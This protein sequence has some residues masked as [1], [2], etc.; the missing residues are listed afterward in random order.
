LQ[1]KGIVAEATVLQGVPI[2][3]AGRFEVGVRDEWLWEGMT[4]APD[5]LLV[6]FDV[7][8]FEGL[9]VEVE[10]SAGERVYE[11]GTLLLSSR[12]PELVLRG[13][14]PAGGRHGES[15]VLCSP[16]APLVRHY[17]DCLL[18]GER[19]GA[20]V[21]EVYLQKLLDEAGEARYEFGRLRYSWGG[22]ED[23]A[24]S[25]LVLLVEG[26]ALPFE[27]AADGTYSPVEPVARPV[28]LEL[29]ALPEGA[30]R[31]ELAWSWRGLVVPL[32]VDGT[33]VLTTLEQGDVLTLELA[34]PAE[35][36]ELLAQFS[37]RRAND[38]AAMLL[39]ERYRRQLVDGRLRLQLP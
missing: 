33:Q 3:E 1:A 6:T 31:L 17:V 18:E 34:V 5:R 4:L 29:A 11:L 39:G 8:G 7:A 22:L 25:E 2:D 32:H 35:G 30:T 20:P 27:R 28:E 10:L 19:G 12:T 38:G 15:S 36:V 16:R 23:F 14:V 37:K 13:A 9:Q 21:T 26:Q 24:P